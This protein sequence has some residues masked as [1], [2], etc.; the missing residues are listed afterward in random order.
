[1]SRKRGEFLQCWRAFLTQR[2]ATLLDTP[3]D[4]THAP[5]GGIPSPLEL[6]GDEPIFRIRCVILTLSTVS[7]VA[8][9]LQIAL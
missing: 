5:E 2:V 7:C 8:G 4:L 3:L 1:L 6:V 9:S